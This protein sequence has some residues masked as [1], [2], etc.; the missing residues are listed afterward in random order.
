MKVRA[1]TTFRTRSGVVPAGHIFDIPPDLL[2]KLGGLVEPLDVFKMIG[3]A[4]AEIDRQG[5]PWTGF[6]G[7]LT[8]ADRRALRDA[9]A[10]VDAAALAGDYDGMTLALDSYKTLLAELRRRL[11]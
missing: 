5:R 9:E 10:A 3:E 6:H 11:H 4:L 8:A 1:T 2:P 7:A